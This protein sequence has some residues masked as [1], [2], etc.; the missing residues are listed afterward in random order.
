MFDFIAWLF[1]HI[2]KIVFLP[3]FMLIFFIKHLV[4]ALGKTLEDCSHILLA[5]FPENN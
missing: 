4:Y 5:K 2:C 1:F 3:V